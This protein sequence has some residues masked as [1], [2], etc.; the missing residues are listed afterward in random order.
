M[1]KGSSIV[2]AMHTRRV[3]I[4]TD[5]FVTVSAVKIRFPQLKTGPWSNIG[6]ILS[7]TLKNGSVRTQILGRLKN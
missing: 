3:Y 1:K 6:R 4:V 5:R 7:A 2:L